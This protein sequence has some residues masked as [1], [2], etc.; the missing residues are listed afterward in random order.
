MRLIYYQVTINLYHPDSLAVNAHGVR[1]DGRGFEPH[2]CS[3]SFYRFSL[4]LLYKLLAGILDESDGYH[5][6]IDI[7]LRHPGF[8]R[9]D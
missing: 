3:S 4:Q 1:L 2:V 6:T 9:V 7:L 5:C 8:L